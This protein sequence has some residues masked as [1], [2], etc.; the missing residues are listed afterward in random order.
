MKEKADR[1]YPATRFTPDGPSRFTDHVAVEQP[2]DISLNGTVIV[3]L[4]CTPTDI[5][6]MAVGY[7][8]SERYIMDI[9]DVQTIDV[10]DDGSAVAV[11]SVSGSTGT[12]AGT[13]S[14]GSRVRSPSRGS[15]GDSPSRGS[16]GDS[17]SPAA[18][19]I[20]TSGCGGGRLSR[21]VLDSASAWRVGEGA[22]VSANDIRVWMK[23]FATRSALY[24]ETGGVHSAAIH[25]GDRVVAFSDDIGR[26]NAVDKVLGRALLDRVQ[27]DR[28][29]VLSTGRI[30]AE[31][32]IKCALREV[33]VVVTR[34]AATSLA[35]DL[36]ERMGVTLA[37]FA[38][39]RRM[40]VYTHSH[41]IT[42]NDTE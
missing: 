28:A 39:G 36:A 22:A 14:R 4:L 42:A 12:F 18:A 27:L 16:A 21:H 2:I 6:A 26:H 8:A 24:R 25:L 11:T 23:Q 3:T 10:A 13:S 38:R 7:L 20:I 1:D 33:S 17:P 35:V 41:R 29:V 30:S 19:P 31:M 9:D 15:A 32:V 40:T 34:S 5:D 37:G